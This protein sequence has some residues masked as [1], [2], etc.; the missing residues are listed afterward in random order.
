MAITNFVPTIW[1]A[2]LLEALKNEQIYTSPAVINRDYEGDIAAYGS[3]VKINSIGDVTVADYT[4]DTN[5]ADPEGLSSEQTTLVIDQAKYFNFLIDD[6]DKAQQNPKLM[7]SAMSQA[8]FN[9]ATVADNFVAALYVNA[10]LSIADDTTPFVPTAATA[11]NLFVD[12][13]TK[14]TEN[15]VPMSGRYAIVPPWLV[16]MLLEDSRFV[17]AGTVATD[18]VLRTGYIGKAAG[19]DIYESNSVPNTAGAK[20]KLQ[21]GHPMAI[22]FADQISEVEA[23]R[24]EKRFADACK[25]LHLY[26]AKVVR[27]KAL[28]IATCS[29]A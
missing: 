16:G 26:G 14:L 24:P 28:L 3:T 13:R 25:G 8:A 29:K 23:Y 10:G 7:D 22:T 27:P 20:Y 9:L 1:S 5:I 21:F 6:I 17:S 15:A 12:A 11:Y 4:K 18:T 19:F 2:R